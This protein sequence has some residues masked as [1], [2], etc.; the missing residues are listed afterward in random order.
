MC[1]GVPSTALQKKQRAVFVIPNVHIF[2]VKKKYVIKSFI[3]KRTPIVSIV[4]IVAKRG[5]R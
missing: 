4:S 2:F 1:I 3:L 5:D